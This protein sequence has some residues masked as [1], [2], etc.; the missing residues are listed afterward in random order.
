MP[1]LCLIYALSMLYLQYYD[2]EMKSTGMKKSEK[3]AVSVLLHNFLKISRFYSLT[4]TQ[5]MRWD[6]KMQRQLSPCISPQLKNQIP[7]TN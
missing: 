6:E 4:S 1:Y 2:N 5:V 7:K 3:D